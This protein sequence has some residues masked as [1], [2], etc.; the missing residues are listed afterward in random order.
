MWKLKD[1]IY[2]YESNQQDAT[3]QVNYYSQSVLRVSGDVFAYH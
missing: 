3:I 2:S 1:N